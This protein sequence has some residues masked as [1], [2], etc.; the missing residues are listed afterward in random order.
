M[1]VF[2]RGYASKDLIAY[3]EDAIHAGYLFR[4]RS[5]FNHAIDALPAPEEPYGITDSILVLDG[6]NVRVLKFYLP[7]GTLETLI[8]NDS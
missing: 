5:R 6:R 4:L 8:T 1:F 3:I 2:D 7:G